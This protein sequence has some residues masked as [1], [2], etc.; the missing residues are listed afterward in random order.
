MMENPQ[1]MDG[2][3]TFGMRDAELWGGPWEQEQMANDFSSMHAVNATT[4]AYHAD[5]AAKHA[6]SLA[7]WVQYLS[8]TLGHLQGK[9]T[10]LE[11][12]KRKAVDEVRKLRDEHKV[13]RQMALGEDAADERGAAAAGPLNGEPV[14][15]AL[16]PLSP[17]PV[18]PPL[19]PREELQRAAARKEQQMLGVPQGVSLETLSTGTTPGGISP[20]SPMG[21]SFGDLD[22]PQKVEGVAVTRGAVGGTPCELVEW[23][24][25]HL[26]MKLRGCMGRA[27]VSPPFDVLGLEDLRLMICPDG[28]EPAQGPRNRRQKELY[29]KKIT[30]GPLEAC[31]KLKIPSCDMAREVEYHMR[32]GAERRGPFRHH[33]AESPVSECDDFAFDWL[34]QLEPDQSLTIGLE[35]L[36]DGGADAVE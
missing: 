25:S 11:D 26:S 30:E 13:L 36:L 24:I 20:L 3:R 28:R 7:Q 33:F 35:I 27:L 17:P 8:M 10:E 32:V 5:V 22:Q 34:K 18:E 31:L 2:E 15:V 14:E 23:R 21:F 29:L 12:W 1:A 4:A 16:Q 9:V 19:P 6:A